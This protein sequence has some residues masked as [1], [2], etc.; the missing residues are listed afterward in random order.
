MKGLPLNHCA[1]FRP[2]KTFEA[3]LNNDG[4]LLVLYNLWNNI[5]LSPYRSRFLSTCTPPCNWI[6]YWR[7]LY[8]AVL[9]IRLKVY[10]HIMKAM[11]TEAF[12]L[13]PSLNNISQT[14][15][16]SGFGVNLIFPFP[17]FPTRWSIYSFFYAFFFILILRKYRYILSYF[18]FVMLCARIL[19]F[20]IVFR[21][22]PYCLGGSIYYFFASLYPQG[23]KEWCS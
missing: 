18:Y 23:R 9:A 22:S 13:T 19:T 4:I 10:I 1:G 11:W 3:D 6:S 16:V 12:F 8:K 5:Y 14:I 17:F 21:C 15:I 2:S 20:K 7:K